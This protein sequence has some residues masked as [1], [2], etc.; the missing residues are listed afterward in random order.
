MVQDVFALHTISAK[1]EVKFPFSIRDY[2]RY[3]FGDDKL[4]NQFGRDLA[5]AFIAGYPTNGNT[6]GTKDSSS[7]EIAVAVLSGYAPAATYNLRD[8]F[9][10]YLN[11]HSIACGGR[12]VRKID[13][14]AIADGCAV[15]R[16]PQTICVDAHHVDAVHLGERM[17]IILGDIRMREDQEN[18]IR[19]SLRALNIKNKVVFVYLAVFEQLTK[20]A[21]LSSALSSVVGLSLKDVDNIGQS[22]HFKMT[23]AFAR[24]VLGRDYSE[25]CRFLRGQDDYFARLLLDYAIG[26]GYYEDELYEQNVKFLLWEVDARESV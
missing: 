21:A 4:A 6:Q 13:I 15:R 8:H 5:K 18:S 2:Q 14:F 12:P 1:E 22:A 9:T 7:N 16:D 25:F 17:L 11:R 26:G 10:A 20:T 3:V 23:E 19:E 24:Y